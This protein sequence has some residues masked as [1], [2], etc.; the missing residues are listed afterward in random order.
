MRRRE[1]C[2]RR[3]TDHRIWCAGWKREEVHLPWRTQHTYFLPRLPPLSLH[4]PP[5]PRRPRC[6]PFNCVRGVSSVGLGI[7]QH[8]LNDPLGGAG[9]G[10]GSG[11][12]LN[13]QSSVN[14]LK[15]VDSMSSMTGA[16]NGGAGMGGMSGEPPGAF[17]GLD[18]FL[19]G[20]IGGQQGGGG[21]GRG[22]RRRKM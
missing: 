22:R 21:G 6:Q 18:S 9:G 7:F 4:S 16:M 8:G 15:N 2:T 12:F 10:G 20:A 11:S 14:S 1:R 13:R 19:E 5:A 3:R 17:S